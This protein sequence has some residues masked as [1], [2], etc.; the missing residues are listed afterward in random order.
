MLKEVEMAP[1]LLDRVVHRAAARL[2]LRAVEAA[3]CLEVECDVE[4][5]LGGI[6]RGRGDEPRRR[7]AESKLEKVG[8]AHGALGWPSAREGGAGSILAA[9]VP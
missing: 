5:P 7:D 1:L 9:R 2:A 3:A 4:T 6:E 8:V